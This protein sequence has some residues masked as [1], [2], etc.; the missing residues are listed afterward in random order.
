MLA[1]AS[2]VPTIGYGDELMAAG[3]VRA[4]QEAGETRKVAILDRHN[5]VRVHELWRHNPRIATREEAAAGNV[6][7]YRNCGGHRPYIERI[8]PHRFTWRPYRPKPGELY[9]DPSEEA[10]GQRH[11]GRVIVNP[12]FKQEN[13]DWGFARWQR[14][15]DMNPGVSFAQ[16]VYADRPALRGV[17][18]IPTPTF[19][20]GAAVLAQSIGIVTTEGGMHHAAAAVN[21]PAV[22]I[23]GGFTA[24]WVTGY[25]AHVNLYA[26][27]DPCGS[28]QPCAHCRDAMASIKVETVSDALRGILERKAA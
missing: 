14:L 12:S 23:F 16:L 25:D 28:R 17:E 7:R 1:A 11:V 4:M 26:G 8:E 15:V 13:K 5:R 6:V 9:F 18:A 3:E 24:P 20:H 27:G 22:V 21:V 19:R 10:F 2:G